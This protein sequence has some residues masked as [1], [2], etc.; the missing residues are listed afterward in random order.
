M[1]ERILLPTDGSEGSRRAIDHAV[2]IADETGASI[3]ALYVVDTSEYK[4]LDGPVVDSIEARGRKALK[5]VEEVGA[6][7]DVDVETALRRGIPHAE[8]LAAARSLDVDGIVMGTN[9]RTGLDRVLLGSVAERVVR[10]AKVPVTTVRAIETA[11]AVDS[12]EE[13]IDRA[14]AALD[15]TGDG[16][17][18]PLEEPYRG[19]S[20]WIVPMRA[21]SGEF[22]VH[23]DAETG[24]TR[25][26]GT[27]D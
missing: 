15:E 14:T 24:K 21:G 9:G 11:P 8:I 7:A 2:A 6:R 1:Y 4:T 16:Q 5:V 20:S 22:R 3:H 10:E 26:A 18:E 25:V 13:A 17:A 27:G 12:P 23:V 19:T